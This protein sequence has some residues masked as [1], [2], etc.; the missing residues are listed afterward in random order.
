VTPQLTSSSA[1]LRPLLQNEDVYLFVKKKKT[2][3]TT[4]T[5][6]REVDPAPSHA[7]RL[8]KLHGPPA[9]W[10]LFF[11]F[12][13]GLGCPLPHN[14]TIGFTSPAI[15]TRARLN[16]RKSAALKGSKTTERSWSA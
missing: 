14:I 11:W 2:H 6:F 9:L 13:A 8:G 16:W 7:P 15:F 5:V 1:L 12:I 4:T 3:W 10:P